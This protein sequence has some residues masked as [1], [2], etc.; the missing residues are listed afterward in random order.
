M[1]FSPFNDNQDQNRPLQ[2]TENGYDTSG[3]DLFRQGVEITRDKF[4]FMGSQP[5]IWS[6]ETT[7]YFS[8]V[9]YGQTQGTIQEDYFGLGSKFEDLPRFDPISY[10]SLG[11]SYPLPIILNDGPNN[12]LEASLEPFT[13]SFRKR[14]N[15]GNYLAHTIRG[16]FSNGSL[17][18]IA[19]KSTN[20]ISQD[21]DLGP[22]YNN[23]YFLDEGAG[24]FGTLPREA[25][26]AD[27]GLSPIPF[28]DCLQFTKEKEL[29]TTNAVIH[30]MIRNGSL[31]ETKNTFGYGKKSASAGMDV[32]GNNTGQYGTDSITYNGW[33]LGS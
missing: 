23:R 22:S 31:K 9:T 12:D 20:A 17:E 29:Q 11:I 27:V 33:L 32:Y 30:Q 18:G 26:V 1:S 13:I 21:K 8:L 25:Y 5:K 3:W 15:E 19:I 16:S 28:D 4:R 10:I 24:Y 7:G 14:S 2:P 6:G